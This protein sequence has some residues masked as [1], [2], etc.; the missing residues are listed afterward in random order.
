VSEFGYGGSKFGFGFSFLACHL[1]PKFFHPGGFLE[2]AYRA[3]MLFQW[4][5]RQKKAAIFFIGLA[6]CKISWCASR[7]TARHAT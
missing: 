4:R 6:Q 2:P 1:T 7:N 5:G 3:A